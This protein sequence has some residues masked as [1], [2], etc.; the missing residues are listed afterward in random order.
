MISFPSQLGLLWFPR[1]IAEMAFT[2]ALTNSVYRTSPG[3]WQKAMNV[4]A[5][6]IDE[7]LVTSRSVDHCLPEAVL[8]QVHRKTIIPE[9]LHRR[10]PEWKVDFCQ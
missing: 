3:Y 4:T 6:H 5:V 2:H 10:A 1:Y 8:G 7:L 9:W